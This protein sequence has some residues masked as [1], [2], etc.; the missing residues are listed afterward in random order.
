MSI[1]LSRRPW[2]YLSVVFIP[3]ALAFWSFKID[4]AYIS[5]VYAKNLIQG[6][7]LTYNGLVV[8]GYSNFLWTLLIAP[9]IGLGWDPLIAARLISLGCSLVTLYLTERLM[10]RFC[11]T[12][13]PLATGLSLLTVGVSVPFAAWTMG[14]L[15]TA[16]MTLEVVLVIF[17]E[18]SAQAYQERWS[19]VVALAGALTRPEGAMLFP[20]IATHRLIMRRQSLRRFVRQ[21]VIFVGPFAVY[22]LW[23]YA[24]YGYWLP[25]TAYVKLD[26]TPATIAAAASWLLSYLQ[27]RPLTAVLLMLGA[28]RLLGRRR[29]ARPD[30]SLVLAVIGAYTVFVLYSGPDW[31]PHHRFLVPVVPL[32]GLLVARALSVFT[33]AWL[34]RA[35][36]IIAAS[37]IV[38]EVILA[39]T[40]ALPVSPRFGDYTDGL[41][42]GGQW[43]KQTTTPQDIIAVVDAGALAYYSER[44]TI[45]ILGLNDSH[46]AH[47]VG[48]SDAAYVLAQRPAVIQLHIE[49]SPT[50]GVVPPT[51]RDGNWDIY[52]QSVFQ[53]GYSPYWAGTADR[54]FPF[55][56]VRQPD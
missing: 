50:G 16:L 48:K 4:D 6:A 27:L 28:V 56:F 45:D 20:I 13:S 25:N 9:F 41:I 53:T 42:R 33:R 55:L 31:M 47:A 1:S 15:E 18:T 52:Q 35:G 10:R 14:G 30:W 2:V 46:I 38:L 29:W 11:P 40:V 49:F 23:R 8:E 21:S 22:L 54:F 26:T 39:L 44:R 3:L 37:G 32:L 12:L 19:M 34:I 24:T 17:L 36:Y 43:I 5:F 7:G 51:E